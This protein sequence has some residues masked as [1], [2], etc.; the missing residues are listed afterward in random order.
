MTES[1]ITAATIFGPPLIGL[2]LLIGVGAMCV[3]WLSGEI[4]NG[5][6]NMK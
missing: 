6:R 4:E 5:R 2:T 1:L 3:V